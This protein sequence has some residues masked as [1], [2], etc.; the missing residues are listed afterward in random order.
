MARTVERVALKSMTPGT[1]RT[2]T[3]FRYGRPGARPKAY[4]QAAIHANEFPG[5]MALHHLVPMLDKADKAGRIRGEIVIVPAA[6]PIG[7]SQVAFAR[8]LGRFDLNGRDNFNR[9]YIDLSAPVAERVT[10]RLGR[11]PA[12]N[13]A[14]IREAGLAVLRGMRPASELQDQ[15]LQLMRRSI[16]ADMVLD[17]H[18][19]S[20]AVLHHFISRR[21]WPAIADLS[22]QIGAEAVLYNEPYAAAMTFMGSNGAWW[23]RLAEHFPAL[24]VPQ[25]CQASTIEYRGEH[26]V[27][28]ELGERDALN[29][30]RFLQRRGAVAGDPGKPPKPLCAATPIAGMDVG[31]APKGGI[32]VYLKPEGAKVNKG[33]AI[34]EVIDPV[35]AD[36]LKARTAMTSAT[37]GVLF[38]RRLDGRL[39]WPGMVC[40]RIAGPK[41]LKHRRGA[42]GLD[43]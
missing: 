21:D 20:R 2:L 31:Y 4:L 18:C 24:P 7:L 37:A 22:A 10:G 14:L 32:V 43:D 41:P 34:C 26:D 16:D 35:A 17:L 9:N 8:H 19:D 39:A 23:A 15:R 25:G 11:D 3:V 1:E 27:T 5:T 6:N 40:Y 42:T 29:L 33:E 13:V 28:H 12:R 36:P 30:Y 38:S